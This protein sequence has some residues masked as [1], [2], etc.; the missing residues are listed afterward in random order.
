M[1]SSRLWRVSTPNTAMAMAPRASG[2]A[3]I[4]AVAAMEGA[5][6]PATTRAMTATPP[7]LLALAASPVPRERMRVGNVSD[8]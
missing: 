1:S 4:N 8:A 2:S 3:P 5:V 7:S 6:A